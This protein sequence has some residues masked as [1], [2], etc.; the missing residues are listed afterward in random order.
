MEFPF[1]GIPTVPPRKDND[2]FA[3]FC[4][5]CRYR[6][7]RLSAPCRR[8]RRPC[9]ERAGPLAVLQT[10]K[11]PPSRA[12]RKR[13]V[14]RPWLAFRVV[15]PITWPSRASIAS[16]A[17]RGAT[18]RARR[19]QRDGGGAEAAPVGRWLRPRRRNEHRQA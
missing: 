5:G 1:E 11:C 18:Q 12:R 13:A 17:R 19:D 9:S 10:R 2:H 8:A 16:R 15:S 14:L 4:D 7:A 6:R 3:F